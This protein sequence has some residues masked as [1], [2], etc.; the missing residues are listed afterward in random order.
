MP[1]HPL[2]L[3]AVPVLALAAA[4]V[5]VQRVEARQRES[6]SAG[7]YAQA[8]GAGEPAAG[9]T[10]VDAGRVIEVEVS[11]DGRTGRTTH[12]SS[13]VRFTRRGP[14]QALSTLEWTRG[15]DGRWSLSGVAG[16]R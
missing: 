7:L 9:T 4:L 2:A 8:A 12:A 14:V 13:A 1:D 5:A 16:R 11:R 15:A 6:G 3:T 10:A